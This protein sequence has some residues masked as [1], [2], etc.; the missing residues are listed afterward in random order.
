MEN[1]NFSIEPPL[2]NRGVVNT[3]GTEILGLSLMNQQYLLVD[4]I[5]GTV[6]NIDDN[7]FNVYKL[8]KDVFDI[9]RENVLE[10]AGGLFGY[11]TTYAYKSIKI[12]SCSYRNDM[13]YHIYIPGSGCRD[14]EDLNLDYAEIFQ[15]LLVLGCK[16][17]RV[18]ISI[19]DYSGKYLDLNLIQSCIQN[20][21]VLS[22]FRNSTE[23][24]KT[25]LSDSSNEGYTIWFGSRASNIQIVFYDKLKERQSQ[26]FIVSN[27][28]KSWVRLE[29]RFRSKFAQDIVTR[30]SCS[31]LSLFKKYY[32]G[33]IFNYIRFVH[34]SYTETNKS[35]WVIQKWWLDFLDHVEKIQFQSINVESSISRSRDWLIHSVSHTNL[36]VLLSEYDLSADDYSCKLIYE[37]LK[38]GSKFITD[39]DIQLINESRYKSG[40]DLITR[41]SFEAF[42]RETKDIILKSSKNDV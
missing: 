36:K 42:I 26:N 25:N 34:K 11:N 32:K 28:I 13:G 22:K 41:E 35:R 4:W 12:M 3:S 17:T 10:S 5:Q 30:F 1:E 37:M 8:F 29:C 15:K 21:E 39:R 9:D 18:D 16:F 14:I 23:F 7:P 20:N 33:I 2:T 19:D 40:L 27:N 24:I 38:T 6:Q 31:T